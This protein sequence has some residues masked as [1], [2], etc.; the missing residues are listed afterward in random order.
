MKQGGAKISGL[1]YPEL[2]YKIMSV[3][4]E[5][6][7]KV[8]NKWREIDFCNA[9]EIVLKRDKINYEREKKVAMEFEG[10]KFA[11]CRLDFIIEKKIVVEVK[12]I[13]KIGEGEIKQTLR[14]LDATNLKLA[15]IT[16][17]K[18]NKIEY[19]RIINPNSLN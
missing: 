4:F 15:I 7:N 9:I 10:S 14:Y 17:I 11:E 6:H 1:I 18:H 13:W 3:I 2:S 16:N 19:R 8:G 5:V 12:K